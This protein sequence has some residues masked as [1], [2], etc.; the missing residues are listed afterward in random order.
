ME[1]GRLIVRAFHSLPGALQGPAEAL[2]FLLLRRSHAG[3][4]V[5]CPCCDQSFR[6]FADQPWP[7]ICPGCGSLPRHRLMWLYLRDEL[8][9]KASR[10]IKLLHVAPE[11]CLATKLRRLDH[12]NYLGI[13]LKPGRAT[14][15]MDVTGLDFPD[16]SFDVIVCSHVL[17]HVEDDRKAMA[18]MFRV[19]R[20]G[21]W[22]ILQSPLDLNRS[23]TFEDATVVDSKRR[24]Q[25]FGQFDHVRAYGRDYVARL[26]AA[27]FSV[28]FSDYLVCFDENELQRLGLDSHDPLCICR[29]PK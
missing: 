5:V 24:E 1:Y 20:P 3:T 26:E 11:N 7:G 12:V 4:G 28:S 16:N 2:F 10:Q 19:L 6:D 13:D 8:D 27:G 21:G 23:E 17:E 18:E 14:S 15:A 29:K 9:E 25:L 22:S